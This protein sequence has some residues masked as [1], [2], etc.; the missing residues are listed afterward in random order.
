ME[1]LI[2][3][4][5]STFEGIKE[6]VLIKNY[7][8][9]DKIINIT[10]QEKNLNKDI[11]NEI[12]SVFSN[13]KYYN[14]N[15]KNYS[16]NFI[17]MVIFYIISQIKMIIITSTP[18][19]APIPST[20]F[21][22]I[23]K[24]PDV[25]NNYWDAKLKVDDTEKI[26]QVKEIRKILNVILDNLPNTIIEMKNKITIL[27]LFKGCI[28][29]ERDI[30]LYNTYKLI[31]NVINQI[32][33]TTNITENFKWDVYEKDR[34]SHWGEKIIPEKEGKISEIFEELKAI[35]TRPTTTPAQ[36]ADRVQLFAD[37]L[38]GGNNH[39][40]K[41]TLKGE[42]EKDKTS[43]EWKTQISQYSEDILLKCIADNDS[44]RMNVCLE[45]FPMSKLKVDTLEKI[46]NLPLSSRMVIAN[47]LGVREVSVTVDGK[48]Y[49]TVETFE[50]WFDRYANKFED[51]ETSEGY[52]VLDKE[53]KDVDSKASAKEIIKFVVHV[54]I[55]SI[56]KESKQ[57]D[58][59]FRESRRK[60]DTASGPTALNFGLKPAPSVF[61]IITY[62]TNTPTGTLWSPDYSFV[63]GNPRLDPRIILRGGNLP[64]C[65]H[66]SVVYERMLT[67][68]T[69]RLKNLNLKMNSSE[70][71]ALKEAIKKIKAGENKINEIFDTIYKYIRTSKSSD[72]G[73]ITK[74]YDSML[75]KL[76]DDV[77]T[78][79]KSVD[80]Y[81][82]R[83]I[84]A[85]SE[86]LS[87][88][89]FLAPQEQQR[90]I[91]FK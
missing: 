11:I 80:E 50:S 87:R 84:K 15:N 8:L 42:D 64:S 53:G 16:V 91:F 73:P 41:P 14:E 52:N 23:F 2:T 24:T 77:E 7:L 81:K 75:K 28:Q 85:F 63:F 21:P 66:S 39:P 22:Q 38:K 65:E 19:T 18:I 3:I 86:M 82:E 48:S 72:E 49:R 4:F 44:S 37:I 17:A 88:M 1:E 62:D 34:I 27:N 60:E 35:F 89:N 57:S 29:W 9:I 20:D 43:D 71:E 59:L 68:V 79:K 69:K 55:D 12:I 36:G 30:L 56:R 51:I 40:E 58:E 54:L 61:N 31:S 45:I 32:T 47:K 78:T 74:G 25:K 46:K 76:T 90:F 13:P 6:D 70:E 67:D 5:K 83:L 10:S 33:P 26:D